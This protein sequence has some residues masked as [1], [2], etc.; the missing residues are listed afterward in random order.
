MASTAGCHAAHLE[1]LPSELLQL[2]FCACSASSGLALACTSSTLRSAKS[3]V[4]PHRLWRCF[5]VN[6]F[7]L[8]REVVSSLGGWPEIAGGALLLSV[9]TLQDVYR[10]HAARELLELTRGDAPAS[11]TQRD[12][13]RHGPFAALLGDPDLHVAAASDVIITIELRWLSTHGELIGSWTGPLRSCMASWDGT[14]FYDESYGEWIEGQLDEFTMPELREAVVQLSPEHVAMT[15]GNPMF[16]SRE[17]LLERL[18][19]LL[20]PHSWGSGAITLNVRDRARWRSI[21]ASTDWKTWQ[22]VRVNVFATSTRTFR[23]A[24]L[25]GTGMTAEDDFGEFERFDLARAPLRSPAQG[26]R[27]LMNGPPLNPDDYELAFDEVAYEIEEAS[28]SQSVGLFVN[29]DLDLNDA[30]F[31][32]Q[33]D[34]RVEMRLQRFVED[35]EGNGQLLMPDGLLPQE[36][37][38]VMHQVIEESR[39]DGDV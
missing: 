37:A 32:A 26:W 20:Q 38:A 16:L 14:T 28:L 9:S 21:C 12:W 39:D 29:L 6:R 33:W 18:R 30:G 1:A 8:L 3:A 7:D 34:G 36:L 4:E 10:A 2:L 27:L 31:V 22:P 35:E 19:S 11:T 13:H 25:M 24:R 23:S 5:L 15:L 17:L